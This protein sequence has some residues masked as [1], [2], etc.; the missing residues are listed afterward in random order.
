MVKEVVITMSNHTT[1]GSEDLN[2][3]ILTALSAS[4]AAAEAVL[5]TT[6][7]V[8]GAG[9]RRG[10]LGMRLLVLLQVLWALKGL[11][12]VTAA[13]RLHGHMHA[14]VRRD[15][16]AL[17]RLDSARVPLAVEAQVVGAATSDMLFA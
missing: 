6:R 12:A 2:G 9:R 8:R 5:A 14:N 15:V 16:V 1:L 3:C 17:D 7:L 4:N 13:V 11:S 10:V